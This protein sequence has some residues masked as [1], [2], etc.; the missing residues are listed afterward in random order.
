MTNKTKTIL[1]VCA[2]TA[3]AFAWN[4]TA[5]G[6]TTGT[7]YWPEGYD[8]AWYLYNPNPDSGMKLTV[9]QA[10]ANNATL[11]FEIERNDT[12]NGFIF[13]TYTVDSNGKIIRDTLGTVDGSTVAENGDIQIKNAKGEKVDSVNSGTSVIVAFSTKKSTILFNNKLSLYSSISIAALN[14][15]ALG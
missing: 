4:A 13:G 8:S 5:E 9:F 2:L 15:S 10:V 7:S 11:S 12:K 14:S 6:E 3:S 1:C